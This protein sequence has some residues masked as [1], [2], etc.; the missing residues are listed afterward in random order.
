MERAQAGRL[1]TD[2]G[3]ASGAVGTGV[4]SGLTDDSGQ[5]REQYTPQHYYEPST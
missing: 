3:M 4:A 5:Y 2:R 1:A